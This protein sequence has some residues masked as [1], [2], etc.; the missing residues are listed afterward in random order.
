MK[1]SG[2]EVFPV[3]GPMPQPGGHVRRFLRLDTGSGLP[4]YGE[5]GPHRELVDYSVE[6][7]EGYVV[8]SVRPWLG[9]QL[10]EDLFPPGNYSKHG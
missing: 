1:I 6:W 9:C 5:L 4:G 10:N 8:P 3:L 7:K 2:V